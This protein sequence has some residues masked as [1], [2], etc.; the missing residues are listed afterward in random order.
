MVSFQVINMIR[1]VCLLA[2]LIVAA[3]AASDGGLR[4]TREREQQQILASNNVNGD[5]LEEACES[6]NA[7][8]WSSTKPPEKFD[9]LG[10]GADAL[11]KWILAFVS[12]YAKMPATIN[13]G[14]PPCCP[15]AGFSDSDLRPLLAFAPPHLVFHLPFTRSRPRR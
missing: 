9:N 13:A 6:W 15:L 2:F 14:E 4:A 12:E 7:F 10:E 5:W 3:A 1:R 8:F 11:N